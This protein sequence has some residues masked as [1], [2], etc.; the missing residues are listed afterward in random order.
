MPRLVCTR[1]ANANPLYLCYQSGWEDYRP[2]KV[3][4]TFA[5]AILISDP[6][7]I[8]RAVH[9]LQSCNEIVEEATEE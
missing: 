9:A 8:H 3:N 1:A 4:A 5:F 6:T 2:V 7:S